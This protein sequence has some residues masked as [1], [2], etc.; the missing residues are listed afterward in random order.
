MSSVRA[1]L[2]AGNM[3]GVWYTVRYA[4]GRGRGVLVGC[5]DKTCAER[6]A[7]AMKDCAAS[8]RDKVGILDCQGVLY[9]R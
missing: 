2:E 8:D 3:R 4:W 9:G 6:I 7:R 1:L 5:C